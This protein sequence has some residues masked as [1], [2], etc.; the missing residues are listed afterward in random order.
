MASKPVIGLTTYGRKENDEYKLPVLYIDAVRRAGGLPVLIPPDAN[1]AEEVCLR[2]DGIIL[3]GG[4]DIN[5]R[6]YNGIVHE[7]NY[8][9]DNERDQGELR[10]AAVILE[11]KIPALAICRGLQILNIHL[12]G[13]LYEHLSETYGEDILHRLPT[14]VACNHKVGIVP[15]TKLAEIVGQAEIEVFSWHHQS[16]KEVAKEMTVTAKSS[17]GVIEG[18]E[19]NNHPWLVGVQWHPEL[20]AAK[21]ILQQRLFNA[22]IGFIQ[23]N[24]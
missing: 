2:M 3:T 20:S 19:I 10:I 7:Q 24:R 22:L 15:G 14:R 17:D 5:P 4:G 12:G 11:K 16:L 23:K 21:D 18:I 8:N 9:N 13:T 6:C 1:E